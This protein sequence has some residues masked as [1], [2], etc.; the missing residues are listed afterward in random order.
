MKQFLFFLI[1]S[2]SLTLFS[3]DNLIILEGIIKNPVSSSITLNTIDD[4]PIHET[5]L[6]NGTFKLEVRVKE[7]YYFLRLGNE[8]T[9]IYLRPNDNLIIEVDGEH[10]QESIIFK[11]K[12]SSRNNYIAS[13]NKRE[14]N[15]RKDLKAFYEGDPADFFARFKTLQDEHKISLSNSKSETSFKDKE[16]EALGYEYLFAIQNYE[17]MQDFYFG[18]KI[19][20]PESFYK[21]LQEVDYDNEELFNSQPFYRYMTSS[22]WKR[23]LKVATSV[24]EMKQVF[25]NINAMNI[26]ND[27]LLSLYYSI[28]KEPEKATDYYNLAKSLINNKEFL[29][30]LKEKVDIVNRIGKGK[31]SPTFTFENHD[32]ST[33][34][35]SELKGTYVF[36][37]IWATWCAPCIQQIPNIKK[38]EKKYADKNLKFVSIS[39]DRA[40]AYN[41]WKEFVANKSLEGIQLYADKS[42][43]SDFIKAYAISSIPRFIIIDPEGNIVNAYAS[44]PSTEQCDEELAALFK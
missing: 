21:P 17:Q 15:I 24:R 30:A 26:K 34:S 32:G 39:V 20:L 16:L 43:E 4:R 27:L 33:T 36:I 37:D 1:L 8:V 31:K 6:D 44:K 42:F 29:N 2:T 5:K 12:G 11:G 35:L 14:K 13:K 7:G 3:Q 38:L 9:D 19:T 41:K 25:D 40:L 23:R 22:M 10:Y 28:S 18:K